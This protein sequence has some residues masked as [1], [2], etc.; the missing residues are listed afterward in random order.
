MFMGKLPEDLWGKAVTLTVPITINGERFRFRVTSKPVE[1]DDGPMSVKV[2][3]A[4]EKKLY[5]T[6]GGKY[7][8]ADIAANGNT[9]PSQKF[10]GIKSSHNA[11]PKAGDKICPISETKANPKFTWVVGGTPYQFCCPPCIDE[12]LQKAKEHPEEIEPQKTKP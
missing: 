4:D 6:P 11:K 10:E 1:H 2:S 9:T 3:G 8:V 5:L 7:T 12:F